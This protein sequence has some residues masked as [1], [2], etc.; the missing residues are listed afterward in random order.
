MGTYR[1]LLLDAD[2]TLLNFKATEDETVRRVLHTLS[3]PADDVVVSRYSAINHALWLAFE[4][5]EIDKETISSVRFVRLFEE[6][7]FRADGV[8]AGALY[9]EYLGESAILLP[10]ALEVCRALSKTHRL[11][12]ITNGI[13]QSQHSRIR[14]SGLAQ[15]V[16]G[17]FVSEEAGAQKPSAAYFDYVFAHLS[18]VERREALIVGD[19]LTS[20]IKGGVNAGVDTCWFNP[21]CLARPAGI[22]PTYEIHALTELFQIV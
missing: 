9:R 10:D 13:F 14:K 8:R 6:F 12:I 22:A 20:D 7:G 17:V 4:R 1:V 19:S 11:Y 2:D 16:S 3:L 18:G 21:A 5:G 15:W